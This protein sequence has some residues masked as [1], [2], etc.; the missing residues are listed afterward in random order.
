MYNLNEC[1]FFYDDLLRD[2]AF[3]AGGDEEIDAAGFIEKVQAEGDDEQHHLGALGLNQR[4]HRQEEHEEHPEQ[5]AGELQWLLRVEGER[6]Q[7]L[8]HIYIE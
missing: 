5:S 1:L 2:G 6:R 7:Q 8:G 3:F 4:I